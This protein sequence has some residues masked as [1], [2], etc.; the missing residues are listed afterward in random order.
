VSRTPFEVEVP[1]V[2]CQGRSGTRGTPLRDLH[3]NHH[4][5]PP[6]SGFARE[7]QAVVVRE[8]CYRFRALRCKEG[9]ADATGFK[10]EFFLGTDRPATRPEREPS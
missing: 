4:R 2:S 9:D 7:E 8:M 10:R 6:G 5:P 1:G 3:V